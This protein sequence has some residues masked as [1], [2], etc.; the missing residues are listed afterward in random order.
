MEREY[1]VR[2]RLDIIQ[3]FF[4]IC[5]EIFFDVLIVRGFQENECRDYYLEYFE[6]ELFFYIVSLRDVV[7]VKE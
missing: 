5:E 7:V 2:F 4:E 3:L 6:G 1:C